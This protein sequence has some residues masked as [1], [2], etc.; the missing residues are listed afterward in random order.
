MGTLPDDLPDSLEQ[1]YVAGTAT[2]VALQR[3]AD[4]F[5]AG[6]RLLSQ[7]S[8][9]GHDHS[10]RAEAALK[11][12]MLNQLPLQRM[13]VIWSAQAFDG[14]D[15]AP[16]H[17]PQRRQAGADRLIVDDDSAGAA[18]PIAAPDLGSAQV[19]ALP[20]EVCERRGWIAFGLE[21]PTVYMKLS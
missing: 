7:K 19:Q 8:D 2:E 20:Q 14:L 10:W 13:Q 9:E 4:I 3:C 16:M 1:L 18:F 12:T 15:I 5:I 6:I 11:G 21:S 17:P